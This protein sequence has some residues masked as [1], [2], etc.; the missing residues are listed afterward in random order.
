MPDKKLDSDLPVLNQN[1]NADSD[2][3]VL[4]KKEDT[5]TTSTNGASTVGAQAAILGSAPPSTS[6]LTTQDYEKQNIVAKASKQSLAAEE[7]FYRE[8]DQPVNE[9]LQNVFGAQKPLTNEEFR[10]QNNKN[11]EKSKII[12]ETYNPII[13]PNATSDERKN[14]LNTKLVEA[15]LKTQ[16]QV[17]LENKSEQEKKYQLAIEAQKDNGV[18]LKDYDAMLPHVKT[19]NFDGGLADIKVYPLNNTDYG[20]V[21]NKVIKWDGDKWVAVTNEKEIQDFN[22]IKDTDYQKQF[23]NHPQNITKNLFTGEDEKNYIPNVN[24]YLYHLKDTEPGKYNNYANKL[25]GFRGGVGEGGG[26]IDQDNLGVQQLKK[27]I[28][29][30][31]ANYKVGDKENDFQVLV[32]RSGGADK[33]NEYNAYAISLNNPNYTPAQKE[34]MQNYIN[35]NFTPAQ[36]EDINKANQYAKDLNERDISIDF[37]NKKLVPLAYQEEVKQKVYEALPAVERAAQDFPKSIY[38]EVLSSTAGLLTLIPDLFNQDNHY[39]AIDYWKDLNNQTKENDIARTSQQP[40]FNED[41]S[42]NPLRIAPA[43]ARMATTMVLF[44]AGA[45]EFEKAV[46]GADVVKG[47]TA[48]YKAGTV[49][50]ALAQTHNDFYKQLE[51]T[52]LTEQQKNNLSLA[53]G[54]AN[55]ISMLFAPGIGKGL[56]SQQGINTM[57]KEY[58]SGKSLDEIFTPFLKEVVNTNLALNTYTVGSKIINGVANEIVGKDVLDTKVK[59]SDFLEN[60]V[61]ATGTS[62]LLGHFNAQ[63]KGNDREQVLNQIAGHDGRMEGALSTIQS[64][65]DSGLITQDRA[66]ELITEL[67]TRNAQLKALPDTYNES[68]KG[69]IVELQN[70]LSG[71]EKKEYAVDNNGQIVEKKLSLADEQAKSVLTTEIQKLSEQPN[72]YFDNLNKTREQKVDEVAK[73]NPDPLIAAMS[74]VK[75]PDNAKEV[76]A[77]LQPII[78]EAEKIASEDVVSKELETNPELIK[79]LPNVLLHGT[80]N[81]DIIFDEGTVFYGTDDEQFAD[82]YGENKIPIIISLK[83]PYDLTGSEDGKIRDENGDVYKDSEGH[84]YSIN[85][86]DQSLKEKL[87]KRGFDGVK[88]GNQSVVAFEPSQVQKATPKSI[89]KIYNQA[90]KDG[91]NPELVKAVEDL[92]T[93]PQNKEAKKVIADETNVVN[94]DVIPPTEIDATI[95]QRKQAELD[96]YGLGD[97]TIGKEF[98]D[99]EK[100][101]EIKAQ[102]K[103]LREHDG[104]I[105][106]ENKAQF[107]DLQK[108]LKDVTF[109]PLT[110]SKQREIISTIDAKYNKEAQDLL[111]TKAE[112]EKLAQEQ[113]KSLNLHNEEIANL[114][115]ER[116]GKIA[117]E[118]MLKLGI[119]EEDLVKAYTPENVQKFKD[120]TDKK[121]EL[122]KLIKCL[123]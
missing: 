90:K 99:E 3:P 88:M 23:F 81:E 49:L 86:I 20:F 75:S 17:A 43:I 91:S 77:E 87:I 48:A 15:D 33:V 11:Y 116:E 111:T 21:D 82:V 95:E 80:N 100:A 109:E 6:N 123:W 83:N 57:V 118:T 113:E 68:K 28:I 101:N 30:E 71:Y 25:L 76:V 45:G 55:G 59:A 117:K 107:D 7:K 106:E 9:D 92:L 61:V 114:E 47:S 102:M 1:Q 42:I 39:G 5:S 32:N 58:A 29:D 27:Q 24:E 50:T 108:Q 121:N 4:K 51:N 97:K 69:A 85:Y 63:L 74:E 67:T 46:Q 84:D 73:G 122:N 18:L 96:Q 119:K 31:A 89:S 34:G 104:T 44:D 115:K 2:L 22:N 37:A 14:L 35:S 112:K 26:A 78:N 110:P 93:T 94:T 56:V 66:N 36:I 19:V 38:N 60:I 105:A 70:Q 62:L 98:K 54:T 103:A 40:V 16:E 41:G 79:S 8:Q 64:N 12:Q 120:L 72:E 13:T 52:D 65:V 10:I 53:L